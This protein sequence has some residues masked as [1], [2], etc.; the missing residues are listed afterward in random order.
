LANLNAHASGNIR[1]VRVLIAGE[2]VGFGGLVS[3]V[4]GEHLG[5][6]YDLRVAFAG[7]VDEVLRLAQDRVLDILIVDVEGIA[8]DFKVSDP[9]LEAGKKQMLQLIRNLKSQYGVPVL[10]L[11]GWGGLDFGE[12]IAEAD[13]SVRHPRIFDELREVVT[14]LIE[15]T[16]DQKAVDMRMPAT[17]RR[18][19]AVLIVDKDKSV[20][21]SYKAFLETKGFESFIA[22]RSDQ[23]LEI[24]DQIQVDIVVTGTL[25]P[26]VNATELTRLIREKY[27]SQVI[28]LTDCSKTCD[29]EKAA[30]MG[31]YDF[32]YRPVLPEELLDSVERIIRRRKLEKFRRK[33]G[34]AG[35]QI[36]IVQDGRFSKTEYFLSCGASAA[37]IIPEKEGLKLMKKLASVRKDFRA[38]LQKRQPGEALDPVNPEIY[39]PNRLFEVFDRLHPMDGCTLDTF[40]DRSSG[41]GLPYVYTRKTSCATV[42]SPEEFNRRFP[43]RK[44]RLRHIEVEPSPSGYFQFAVFNNMVSQFHLFCLHDRG[45]MQPVVTG[46][47]LKRILDFSVGEALK[48][49][50]LEERAIKPRMSVWESEGIVIVR[51]IVSDS[52]GDLYFQQTYIRS[53]IIEHV[54]RSK[55]VQEGK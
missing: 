49:E 30:R 36:K 1:K 22:L 37:A 54:S 50:L 52:A 20:C 21:Q 5:Q 27:D 26:D 15:G 39:D 7:H 47:Q 35:K 46:R 14:G 3:E 38:L 24:L 42:K 2:P 31:A 32:L 48:R 17:D 45:F 29:H 9:F 33:F 34:C 4:I 13:F 28:I 8:F 41:F 55:I 18:R 12:R 23:A 51:F 53:N 11:Y 6:K 25:M 16:L 44:D 10:A 40:L 19:G 43:H